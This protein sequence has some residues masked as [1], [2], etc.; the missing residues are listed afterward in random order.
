M[1]FEGKETI[2]RRRGCLFCKTGAENRAALMA[3]T[4]WPGVK[5]R[6]VSAAKRHSKDGVKS[7][8]MDVVMPGY[9]FF[10]ADEGFLPT[11]PFPE[12]VLRLLTAVSGDW[13]LTGWDDAFARWLMEHDGVLQPSQAHREDGRIVIHAGPLKE[14]EEYVVRL[15]R[16]NANALVQLDVGGRQV[17]TWLPYEIV[18]YKKDIDMR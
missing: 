9:V 4:L 16:R 3:E 13:R 5:A 7:I 11:P 10:E 18:E 15:D 6:S 14:F 8:R 2:K 17:R 1:S 12:D